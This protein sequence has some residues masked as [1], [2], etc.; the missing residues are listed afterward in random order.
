MAVMAKINFNVVAVNTLTLPS[1]L[2]HPLNIL[3]ELYFN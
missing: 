2:T 3:L 1:G